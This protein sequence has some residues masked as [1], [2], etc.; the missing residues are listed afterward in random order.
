MT[1][2][3]VI[4]LAAESFIHCSQS[5]TKNVSNIVQGPGGLGCQGEHSLDETGMYT[6]DHDSS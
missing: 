2:A 3:F 4:C 1:T 6:Q 5:L